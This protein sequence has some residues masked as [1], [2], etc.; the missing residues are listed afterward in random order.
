MESSCPDFLTER[1]S[2]ISP[3]IIATVTLNR[4]RL[5][6][7]STNDSKLVRAQKLYRESGL[8]FDYQFDGC[9]SA[10]TAS[11]VKPVLGTTIL[12]P[13]NV[14]RWFN[15]PLNKMKKFTVQ[16]DCISKDFF[17]KD[18]SENRQQMEFSLQHHLLFNCSEFAS[19]F[20]VPSP[21]KIEVVKICNPAHPEIQKLVRL[22]QLNTSTEA[23][24]I[25]SAFKFVKD[26]ILYSS[27]SNWSIP[28]EYT[29]SSRIGMYSTKVCLLAAIL[30]AGGIP[31]VLFIV[32]LNGPLLLP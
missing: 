4:K 32:K 12:Y 1:F 30:S 2:P 11:L 8:S 6:L 3:H 15:L 25:A 23:D 5:F 13:N 24:F 10:W 17:R 9:H 16:V 19:N 29:H 18:E 14:K 27:L 21:P 31:N 28:V 26:E 7:D 20:Q 22:F